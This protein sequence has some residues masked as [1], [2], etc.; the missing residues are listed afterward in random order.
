MKGEVAVMTAPGALAFQ[1]YDVPAPGPGAVIL[2]VLRANVCGSEIHIWQG[3]HPVKKR[4]GIGHE[5]VGVV[6]QLG[7][8][9]SHDSAG[10]PLSIGD[11][12]VATYFQ[13]CLSC[14]QCLAGQYNLCDNA[15]AF[16]GLQPEQAPHF[17]TAFATHVYIHPRQHLYKVPANIPDSVAASANCA[18]SQVYFGL[19]R[20]GV[21]EGDTVVIQGAGGLGLMGVALAR[22]RGARVIVIDGIEQRLDQARAFGAHEIVDMRAYPSAADRQARVQELTDGRGADVGVE[23]TGVPA[24]FNEGV[25]GLVRRGGRYLVMG[26]LSPG[27]TIDLDP[28]LLTRRSVQILPVDRYDGRYLYKALR[29]LEKTLEQYPYAKLLD[30]EFPLCCVQDA[31]E[32]SASREVTRASIV[33]QM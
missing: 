14:A 4:G 10:Q 33:M 16:F 22:E 31:L 3:K 8:G 6:A 21:G 15:Y 11:R 24:A 20:I 17:H 13:T 18:L 30:A 5:M 2:K 29:F 1:T 7:E 25:T 27:A 23:V 19:D 12:V 32:K 9:V 28:G 26:N